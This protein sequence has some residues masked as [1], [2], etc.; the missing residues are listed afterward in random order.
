MSENNTVKTPWYPYTEGVPV[1]LDYFKGSMFDMVASVAA[2]WPKNVAF[3]F[4]GK[5]TTYARMIKN[6]EQCARAL[7]TI[8]IRKGAVG[9]VH[10]YSPEVQER[11]VTLGLTTHAKIKRNALIFKAVCVPGYIAYVLVCVYALNGAKGF[12]QGFWQLLVILSVMNLIDRFWVDGYWVGH[13][14][15]WE[16]PGTEDLKPYITAKDKGKKWLFGTIGMA[17]IS[18]ALAAIM[19]L[20]MKI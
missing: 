18:A 7:K 11:C 2:R 3:D 19:M 10:L 6:I 12:V 1:H 8:G 17:V 15:A 16:I 20:F 5:S 9:M 14:N 13:T 4:M